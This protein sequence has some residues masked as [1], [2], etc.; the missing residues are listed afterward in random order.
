MAKDGKSVCRDV[1]DIL[2]KYAVGMRI[3]REGMYDGDELLLGTRK[4]IWEH[5]KKLLLD[6]QRKERKETYM[7]RRCELKYTKD[8]KNPVTSVLSVT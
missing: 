2:D 8:L 6:H 1:N 7:R 4:D 3:D 5:I